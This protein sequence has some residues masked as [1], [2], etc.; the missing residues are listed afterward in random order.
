MLAASA[1]VVRPQAASAP[2]ELVTP[3]TASAA[4]SAS[5]AS[6]SSDLAEGGRRLSSR[7]RSGQVRASNSSGA[8]P[9]TGSSGTA[10]AM[11]T[12]RSA[13]IRSALGAKSVEETKAWRWPTN[14][15]KPRSRP[16][17]LSSFSRLPKRW[18]TDTDSPLTY[19]ASA[20]SAP[21]AFA[22]FMRSASRL[23]STPVGPCG[24][25]GAFLGAV[26]FALAMPRFYALRPVVV[27][28]ADDLQLPA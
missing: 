13:R 26:R 15:R 25:R 21:D 24:L 22:H 11:S 4:S 12:A 10:R 7:S 18:A 6:A 2:S 27:E 3:L 16:S 9:H 23:A 20:A 19:R 28:T 8:M 14:T 5:A 1:T 17:L